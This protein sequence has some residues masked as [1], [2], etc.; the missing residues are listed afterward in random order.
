M[1]RVSRFTWGIMAKHFRY[2]VFHG[3]MCGIFSVRRGSRFMWEALGNIPHKACSM[4][5]Q[6]MIF[7]SGVFHGL[8]G[9]CS[10]RKASFTVWQK[11]IFP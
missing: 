7:P 2:G 9:N 8:V 5:R 10:F 11:G 4:V 1:R 6:K 3:S